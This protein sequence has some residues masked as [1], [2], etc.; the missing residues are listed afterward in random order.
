MVA[1]GRLQDIWPLHTDWNYKS[2][3][4]IYTA[5]HGQPPLF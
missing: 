4:W 5:L 2:T 1:K 3:V